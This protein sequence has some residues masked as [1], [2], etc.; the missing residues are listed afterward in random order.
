MELINNPTLNEI[1]KAAKALK[2]GH[3]VA[4]PTETVY[5]L[6]ADATN[7]KAVSRIYSVK[8][9]PS[10]HPLIVHISSINQ[11]NKWAKDI[12]DYAIKLAKEFWPGPITLILK[13]SELA[14][15][16]IT[17]GQSNVG[18]RVP[19]Q[20]VALAL[21]SE[22]EKL[23]GLG[24]AA[25]SAN[26][27]GAVSPTSS[28][29]VVDELGKYFQSEDLI[30]NGGTCPV[31]IESAIINCLG[32]SPSILRPGAITY[33]MISK[34]IEFTEIKDT[35]SDSIKAP[36]NLKKHYSPKAKIMINSHP[37]K[38]EGLIALCNIETPENV[39]RLLAPTNLAEYAMGL[40]E[41]FRKGDKLNLSVINIY[42]PEDIGLGAAIN[43]R[44]SKARGN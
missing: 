43:D 12:P 14:K 23:G 26:R 22:F 6:G 20:P 31:G 30:L 36:G 40:Y 18:L 17:G 28:D 42:V 39:E 21:L 19:N 38:G 3:L 37:K 4:F 7:G 8:G 34:A 24:I 5:G 35:P 9:R 11:L 44:I 33:E 16:Y 1:K 25:P 41:A 13:R 2:A 32:K 15:D 27:F 10:D 29:A